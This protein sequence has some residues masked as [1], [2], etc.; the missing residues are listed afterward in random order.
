M[1][2]VHLH[3]ESGPSGS[4]P[5]LWHRSV[6]EPLEV[7][8]LQLEVSSSLRFQLTQASVLASVRPDEYT[9]TPGR[10]NC[11]P[12]VSVAGTTL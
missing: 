10:S 12:G 4:T 6:I 2:S 7:M 11:T 8:P 9:S 3:G 1:S 5:S